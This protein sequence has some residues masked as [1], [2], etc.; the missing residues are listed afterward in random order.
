M[1]ANQEFEF[2]D[3]LEK[4]P[5]LR[6]IEEYQNHP[7]IKIIKLEINPKLFGSR[8]LFLIKV[9]PKSCSQKSISKKLQGKTW[10]FLQNIYAMIS[11]PQFTLPSFT[12]N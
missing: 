1:S 9:Y 3:S 5:L 10:L 6:I 8:K 12:L 4:D 2:L 11:M 7:S